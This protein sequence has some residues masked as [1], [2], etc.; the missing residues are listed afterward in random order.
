MTD[1]KQTLVIGGTGNIGK[2]VVALL[3]DRGVAVRALARDP[4]RLPDGVE[5]V[6][7]TSRTP[8]PCDRRSPERTRCSCSGPS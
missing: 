4:A 2:H 7:A 1:I 8:T 6:R 5:A 3:H